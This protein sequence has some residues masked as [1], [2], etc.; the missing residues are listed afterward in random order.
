MVLTAREELEYISLLEQEEHYQLGRKLW[1]YFP[2]TGPLRRELYPK[3]LEFFARGAR[4]P[5]RLMLKGNRVGGTEGFG[6]ELSYHLTG[7]YPDWWEGRVFDG[8]IV[9]WAAGDSNQ[10]TQEIIQAKLFGSKDY[11]L[12]TLGTGIIPRDSIVS[13]GPRVGVPGAVMS[14]TIKHISGGA[15][16]LTLKSFEQGVESFQGNE[17]HVCWLDELAPIG[18]L[19]ECVVRITPTPWFPGGMIAWTVTPEHGI[20][21]AIM[22]F[23]P[24]GTVPEGAQ[25]P[26]K[27]VSLIGWD[28]A[29][30]LSE[31]AKQVLEAGI[32]TY[33]LDARKRGIPVLGAGV[34]YP[35]PEE[36]YLVD[37]FEVPKHW[38]RAYG[39]DV[40]WNWTA[41]PWGAYDQE[42]DT[43]YLYHEYKRG[44]AEPSTHAEAI[45]APGE[46]IHGVIDSAANGRSQED[47]SRLIE[48]Y[49]GRGLKLT[50]ADKSIHAGIYEIWLR[51]TTGR[52][53]V[54]RSLT[55]WRKEVRLYR[56]DDKGR[57]VKEND[58][59]MDATRYLIMS[60]RPVA[61][62]V[63]V[64]ADPYDQVG[65]MAA[66]RGGWMG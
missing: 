33:Q 48:S 54:F 63:P 56:R 13:I 3:H 31:A 12:S 46:W 49:R 59:L 14:A 40:G 30:H 21:Q 66:G 25:V 60:G 26:P 37:D 47:G 8:P 2:D 44:E 5:M 24:D 11:R 1:T 42:T 19:T 51:L 39:L 58:H 62:A 29:P 15:S 23:L 17:V 32:P 7:Q 53:K 50:N 43:W 36:E 45:R 4:Y 18:V 6:C 52:L 55:Q 28:D 57:I 35:V 41:A 61:K 16:T 38:L 22:E 10:K 9:A 64:A 65:A 20:T 27:W 34:I